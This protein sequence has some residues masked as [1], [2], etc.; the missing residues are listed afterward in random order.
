MIHLELVFMENVNLGWGSILFPMDVQSQHY[1]KK[2]KNYHF[3]IELLLHLS[4]NQ[5][6]VLVWVSLFC[7]IDL[8]V[9][10][11]ASTTLSWLL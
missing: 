11:F 3:S 2:K 1:L 4:K 9:H 6:A 8:Y 7:S 10:S 5:L